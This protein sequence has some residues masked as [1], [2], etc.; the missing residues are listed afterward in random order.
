M[1]IYTL[2]CH[3]KDEKLHHHCER[4]KQWIWLISFIPVYHSQKK[5]SYPY[6]QYYESAPLHLYDLW[7]AVWIL[8]T[9]KQDYVQHP[10]VQP[11]QVQVNQ[12]N[13]TRNL[14]KLWGVSVRYVHET[15]IIASAGWWLGVYA[16]LTEGQDSRTTLWKEVEGE[17]RRSDD[18]H[19]RPI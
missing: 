19:A 6:S 16:T 11:S 7:A 10:L 8:L 9:L 13:H 1:D 2:K 18:F 17:T 4:K 3:V 15:N 14:I 5:V 12:S